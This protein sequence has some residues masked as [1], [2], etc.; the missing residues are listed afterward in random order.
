MFS[1][2]YARLW[3]AG[4]FDI[5][6]SPGLRRGYLALIV[7]PSAFSQLTPG[8]TSAHRPIS[9]SR[10]TP[11]CYLALIIAPS[12]FPTGYAGGY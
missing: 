6:F 2:S 10:L 4:R 9:I 3:R 1:D 7:A 8:A 11:G 12:S 5:F